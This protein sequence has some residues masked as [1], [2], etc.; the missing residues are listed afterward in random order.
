MKL[1][2]KAYYIDYNLL[3]NDTYDIDLQCYAET[4]NKARYILFKQVQMENLKL[5]DGSP[6]TYSNIPIKRDSKDL[7]IYEFENKELSKRNI[8]KIIKKRER[9]KELDI[10]LDENTNA[11]A[12]IKKNGMYY[13]DGHCGYTSL[14]YEAGIYTI[15]DAI[16]SAK[17][18][19]DVT[20]QIIDPSV[21]NKII[22]DKIEFLKKHL[23]E[24]K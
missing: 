22:N 1:I 17:R 7:D 10:V 24:V 6:L 23:I 15:D 4:R 14:I 20:I 16:D 11:K 9:I 8:D 5:T 18:C 13:R 19:T 21:H 3:D 12:Y 2:L